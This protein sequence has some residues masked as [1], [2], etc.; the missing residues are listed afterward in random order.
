MHRLGT[1]IFFAVALIAA[2]V[3]AKIGGDIVDS[4]KCNC[5]VGWVTPG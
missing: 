2:G 4:A 1:V 5:A 3:G